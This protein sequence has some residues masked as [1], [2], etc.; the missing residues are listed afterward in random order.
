M[1]EDSVNDFLTP[2]QKKDDMR[3]LFVLFYK[4][5]QMKST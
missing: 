1:T 5:Y 2:V 4:K 3:F